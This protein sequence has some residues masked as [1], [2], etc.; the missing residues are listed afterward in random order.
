MKDAVEDAVKDAVK[1]AAND[2]VQVAK[3]VVKDAVED[4]AK[5]VADIVFGRTWNKLNGVIWKNVKDTMEKTLLNCFEK[6]WSK[7]FDLR[8]HFFILLPFSGSFE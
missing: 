5:Y 2:A 3:D 1:D 8:F 7:Y 6:V 4:A